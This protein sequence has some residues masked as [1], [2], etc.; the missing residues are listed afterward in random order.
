MTDS[1]ERLRRTKLFA[2]ALDSLRIVPRIL[3]TLY[4]LMTYQVV[5][6][7]M[8]LPDPNMAQ[9]GLVST[10]VGGSAAVFNFYVNTKK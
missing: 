3:V 9:A 5:D 10:I 7:F 6:W 8:S 4:G 1:T 2:E